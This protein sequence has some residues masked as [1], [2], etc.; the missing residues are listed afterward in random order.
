[1]CIRDSIPSGC[2]KQGLTPQQKALEFLF[3]DMAACVVDSLPL[4]PVPPP[5]PLPP[6]DAGEADDAG[7]AGGD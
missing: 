6:C 1:M 7:D 5:V 4:A 3:F 2:P